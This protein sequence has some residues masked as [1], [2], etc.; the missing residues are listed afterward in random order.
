MYLVDGVAFLKEC[1]GEGLFYFLGD[2][3]L[4]NLFRDGLRTDNYAV[5][6]TDQEVAGIDGNVAA[7]DG[8]LYVCC[9]V[10]GHVTVAVGSANENWEVL[11]SKVGYVPDCAVCN[12]SGSA[13][14]VHSSDE[15][16]SKDAGVDVAASADY[17]DVSRPDGFHGHVLRVEMSCFHGDGEHGVV[18]PPRK[19]TEGIGAPCKDGTCLQRENARHI[20]EPEAAFVELPRNSGRAGL[21][22]LLQKFNGKVLGRRPQG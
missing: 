12:E 9:P 16:I 1:S 19:V 10:F 7:I 15:S 14:I 17:Q 21:L 5:V 6:V 22:C 2:G 13:K 11:V 3:A 4:Y 20:N 8:Q 18:F